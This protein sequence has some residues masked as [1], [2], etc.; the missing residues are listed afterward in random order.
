MHRATDYDDVGPPSPLFA[1]THVDPGVLCSMH[2]TE[3][4]ARRKLAAR[5]YGIPPRSAAS[6]VRM[7]ARGVRA[8]GSEPSL[9]RPSSASPPLTPHHVHRVPPRLPGGIRL[10]AELARVRHQ[11]EME[12]TTLRAAV[13]RSRWEATALMDRLES[14][15]KEISSAA[16]ERTGLEAEIMRL[17]ALLQQARDDN[18]VESLNHQKALRALEAKVAAVA[19]VRRRPQ[20]E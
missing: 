1:L 12:T 17:N 20:H 6:P 11:H 4:A 18:L 14:L 19:E 3:G 8:S 10:M 5:L 9:L 13:E 2:S 16:R 15:E 7:S